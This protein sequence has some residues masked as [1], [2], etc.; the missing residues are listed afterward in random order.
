MK[1][2]RHILLA[3]IL[4]LPILAHGADNV[5]DAARTVSERVV[6]PSP[7]VATM[8]RYTD[9]PV[10]YAT[11]SASVDIPL[12]SLSTPSLSVSLGLSYRCEAKKVEEPAGWVGLGWT[13]TGL[14]SVSRQICGMPDDW[15]L[16]PFK[17]L[18][19]SNDVNYF[20]DLLDQK[21]DA[22][23]DRYTVTTPDGKSVSFMILRHGTIEMLGY[24]ELS[25]S[26][27]EGADNEFA[28]EKFIVTTPEGIVYEYTEKERIEYHYDVEPKSGSTHDT[29]YTATTA[30]HI[31][32]I[33]AP[34]RS[35][36][37]MIDYS[38]GTTWTKCKSSDLYSRSHYWKGEGGNSGSSGDFGFGGISLDRPADML[39]R[40]TGIPSTANTR[41][42]DPPLPKTIRSNSGRIDL[43]FAKSDIPST[44]INGTADRLKSIRLTSPDG[45]VVRKAELD[46]SDSHYSRR[47]LDKLSIYGEN[48]LVEGYAYSYYNED[49]GF[50]DV[51]GYPNGRPTRPTKNSI[52]DEHLNINETR[53]IVPSALNAALLRRVT[54][55]TGIATDFVYEPATASLS[56]LN[57]LWG[58]EIAIG[59]RIKSITATDLASG[60]YRQRE[61][62]YYGDTLDIDI[63]KVW[64]DDFL[65][66]S[67]TCQHSSIHNG[68]YSNFNMSVT[69]TASSR[70][71]GRPVESARV[72]YRAVEE[73]LSGN[74]MGA[75]VKTRYEYDVSRCIARLDTCGS[76]SL[77]QST[78]STNPL[79]DRKGYFNTTKDFTDDENYS[80]FNTHILTKVFVENYGAEPMLARKVMYRSHVGGYEP[81]KTEEYS[82]N[83]KSRNDILVGLFYESI[84]YQKYLAGGSIGTHQPITNIEH[85]NRGP[86]YADYCKIIPRGVKT[87]R[88]YRG[89]KERVNSVDYIYQSRIIEH[90]ADP[91]RPGVVYPIQTQ[92]PG[93]DGDS[94]EDEIFAERHRPM[95]VFYSCGGDTI[96]QCNL[97][98]KYVNTDFFKSQ[99]N[100]YLPVAQKW[101]MT[102]NGCTD[103]LEAEW[104][105]GKFHGMTRPVRE[106]VSRHGAVLDRASYTAYNVLGL[107]T[108]MTRRDGSEYSMG[109]DGYGNLISKKLA[110]V[111]LENRYTYKQLVGCTSISYPSGRKKYFSYDNGRLS[112]V[113]NSANE[114][115]A[116]YE[117]SMANPGLNWGAQGENTITATAYTASGAAT[118]KAV[119]DGF[120]MQVS[121]I[122]VGFG[123]DGGDVVTNT[124]YYALDRAVRLWQP[125]PVGQENYYNGDLAYTDNVYDTDGSERVVSTTAPGKDMIGH[126]ATAEYLCN[127]QSGELRCRR[128]VLEGERLTD[129]GAYADASLDVVRAI[130]ADG[131]RVLTFSDWRGRTVLVRKVLAEGKYIDTYTVYDHWGNVAVVLQPMAEG[132]LKGGSYDI[133]DGGMDEVIEKYAYVYRYDD[134]LRP[135]YAKLPGCDP[136]TTVYD[137]DGL[138]AYTVDGNLRAKG[139]ARFTL[140]DAAARPVVT[141]ICNEPTGV[142]PRM[143][144][145]FDSSDPG[146]D[147]TYYVTDVP[148]TDAVVYTAT[149]YDNYD[150]RSHRF[151]N[152]LPAGL[153]ARATDAKGLVTGS[154]ERVL[155]TNRFIA[156]MSLYDK[157][158]RP[159]LTMQTTHTPGVMTIVENE[160]NIDGTVAVMNNKLMHPT[161]DHTDSHT[162]AYDAA[163]R[164]VK[165]TVSYDGG[166]A[167]DVQKLSYNAIGTLSGNDL[168]VFNEEYT[169]NVRGAMTKRKSAVFEQTIGFSNHFNRLYNGSIGM[170]VDKLTGG[171]STS[172]G[173]SYDNA[174]RLTSAM[175]FFDGITHPTGYT[176]DLNSNITTLNRR[177]YNPTNVAELIDNLVY[178]Y[179]G[180]QVKKITE[181]A[182]VVISE[183]TMNFIDGADLDVEYT[184]DRNGNMTSDANKGL[185]M[186]WDYNNRLYKVEDDEMTMTFNRTG[187]GQKLGKSVYV[188][189]KL[190][191]YL[192]P[193]V[194]RSNSLGGYPAFPR[195]SMLV[196][197][198]DSIFHIG[199][200]TL[201]ENFGSYEYVN[202]KFA[203]LNTSTGYRDSEG[204][205]VYVRDWQGNIRAVVRKGDDGSTVLEQA[206]YYY[207]YG[208]PMAESTNPT[209][210]R[211]KYTGKELLTNKGFN[212]YDFGPRPYDPVTCI[213]LRR[214]DLSHE[215]PD[216]SHNAFCN[217]DPIN[218]IDI[219]GNR[220]IVLKHES[221]HIA[222]L[223]QNHETGKYAYYSY[224]GTGI[225]FWTHGLLGGRLYH[226]LGKKEFKSIESFLSSPYNNDGDYISDAKDITCGYKYTKAYILPTTQE[227][228]SKIRETFIKSAL[229]GYNLFGHNCAD[230]VVE[231]LTSVYE[232]FSEPANYQRQWK[233]I[234][235]WIEDNVKNSITLPSDVLEKIMN[236]EPAGEVVNKK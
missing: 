235:K 201:T 71:A 206:T 44:H 10:S 187:S 224:N 72:Y 84:I 73:T 36:S 170:I 221:E 194:S 113:R 54:T 193:G 2:I 227:Q 222:L 195:D 67:G 4:S 37:I 34:E 154:L 82:Y 97:Y 30:W 61:F 155:G 147:S 163:G 13:L 232:N 176:Y 52:L 162:Y 77:Y 20:N 209:A 81:W 99:P 236:T 118:H 146:L 141:G 173:Y 124:E 218:N 68:Q 175:I 110:S 57:P 145:G 93:F 234:F 178:Q 60:R 29:Y 128:F 104:L 25:I 219:D 157:E 23:P 53:S 139:N 19:Y 40:T 153:R 74:D 59:T 101:I 88:H 210:N 12:M 69:F 144:A 191:D 18:E 64:Y 150:F 233:G 220:T 5:P 95:A 152:E 96:R 94:I 184:Y 159:T 126:P 9:C 205:H 98:A 179:D 142:V 230:V 212:C 33:I 204:T 38:K 31:T 225:N 11:G 167:V 190:K 102:E 214:D 21:K 207:P 26:R 80:T 112:Q 168:G 115:V 121:D 172:S 75:P 217:G 108:A 137:P 111:G 35:D 129:K 78:L 149:Y 130:D 161:G 174:G 107:P 216:F 1:P 203:R 200:T 45:T 213:W 15:H 182:P 17:L 56:G 132:G 223:I 49:N 196:Y 76:A 116:S 148:L 87:I 32:K 117:Y 185:E 27:V 151:F 177:G 65:A 158:E 133:S 83:V 63:D 103:T 199:N 143:R 156:S 3:L 47:F 188:G 6:E 120:G 51:F 211:Y 140:Y 135:V 39:S 66:S 189:P 171:K 100:R 50:G 43:E 183:K 166:E 109:W 89:G 127:T 58:D 28:T 186:S 122:A 42:E 85:I 134:A 228:D 41:Y 160:Y 198:T 197:P 136:V 86:V 62:S 70:R 91:E 92:Y 165:E 192:R 14:G 229:R 22:N 114:P 180:N 202:G 231:A 215:T 7:D 119:Y 46:A 24:S 106:T 48:G 90:P 123:G 55:E 138:V 16:S 105:Y 79:L 226:N 8:R 164:L 131:H 181:K 208:M 125:L 169:Y